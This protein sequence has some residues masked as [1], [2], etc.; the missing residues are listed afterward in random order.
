M[1][2]FVNNA[3][4]GLVSTGDDLGGVGSLSD[5]EGTG[6]GAAAVEEGSG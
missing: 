1:L 6:F 2:F 4:E 3:N 5:N